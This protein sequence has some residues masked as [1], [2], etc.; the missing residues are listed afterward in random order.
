[1]VI[2]IGKIIFILNNNPPK[3]LPGKIVEQ[4]ISRKVNAEV[5][6]HIVEF[7][8]GKDYTLEDIKK[9]WFPSLESARNY[10]SQ[11][12]EKL[13]QSVIDE[14][15]KK[16]LDHFSKFSD[17]DNPERTS[18]LVIEQAVEPSLPKEQVLN[19]TDNIIVDLGNGQKAKLKTPEVLK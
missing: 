4:I 2:D 14:G 10:L 17:F 5:V 13:I 12:A 6:T 9:P 11:E 1:M 19:S 15:K 8:N 16:A 3:L 7:P 18:E